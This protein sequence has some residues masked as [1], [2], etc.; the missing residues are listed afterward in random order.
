M[1]YK[2]AEGGS[3]EYVVYSADKIKTRSQLIDIWKKAQDADL[4]AQ[5]ALRGRRMIEKSNGKTTIGTMLAGGSALSGITAM[6][7][8]SEQEYT[9]PKQRNE[10]NAPRIDTAAIKRA[11]AFAE[12][13]GVKGNRNLVSQP[14]GRNELGNDNGK[15]QV[16]DETL[17]VN[18]KR[19]L[20]RQVSREE[21]LRN[22]ELQEMFMENEIKFL[23][24]TYGWGPEEIIAAHR[25]GFSKPDEID[26][27]RKEKGKYVENAMKYYQPE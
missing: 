7:K 11:I 18:S 26:R 20:G 5:A 10:N 24:E 16:T 4:T 25:G 1:K 22:P 8:K 15:Y 23:A 14:S 3:T 12:T 19:F 9:K 13:G 2:H 21:F 27:I 6:N 17:R